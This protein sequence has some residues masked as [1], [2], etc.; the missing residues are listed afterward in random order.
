MPVVSFIPPVRDYEFGNW[1]KVAGQCIRITSHIT[2]RIS[3]QTVIVRWSPTSLKNRA[4][5]TINKK[6]LYEPSREIQQQKVDMM[7]KTIYIPVKWYGMAS[8]GE[9]KWKGDSDSSTYSV[10]PNNIFRTSRAVLAKSWVAQLKKRRENS[11]G[12]GFEGNYEMRLFHWWQNFGTFPQWRGT[13]PHV[14]WLCSQ[15]SQD[16]IAKSIWNFMIKH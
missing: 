15:S 1:L 3:F 7:N 14:L 10:S 5:T 13:F 4:K 9:W 11:Q 16:C 2:F 8:E 12:T 6:K